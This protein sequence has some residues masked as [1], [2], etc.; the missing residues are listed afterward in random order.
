MSL[1][2]RR[3]DSAKSLRRHREYRYRLGVAVPLQGQNPQ[4]LSDIED[5]LVGHFESDQS[6]LLVLVLTAPHFRE[7]VF[8]TR[9]A[10]ALARLEATR[11]EVSSHEL[12]GC[13]NE[14]PSWELYERFF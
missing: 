1:L 3:N 4:E 13:L 14:D 9:D 8:Y 12:Q 7:F 2:V 6:G 11:T 5:F 10:Q